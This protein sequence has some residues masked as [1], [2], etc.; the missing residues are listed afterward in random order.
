MKTLHTRWL[1][2]ATILSGFLTPPLAYAQ[3]VTLPP[4][5][6]QTSK[7][8]SVATRQLRM[9]DELGRQVLRSYRT[10]RAICMLIFYFNILRLTRAHT[11]RLGRCRGRARTRDSTV[12]HALPHDRPP[13]DAGDR[14]QGRREAN[15]LVKVST[16]R[17]PRRRAHRLGPPAA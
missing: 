3:K 13:D 10:A 1:I 4:E 7:E 17:G 5:M 11:G 12:G 15:E 8:L 14:P 6:T 16:E 9:A 2:V